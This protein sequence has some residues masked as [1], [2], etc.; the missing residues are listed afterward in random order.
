MRSYAHTEAATFESVV[1][2]I[3]H[4]KRASLRSRIAGQ[5]LVGTYELDG[6]HRGEQEAEPVREA[7]AAAEK[8]VRRTTPR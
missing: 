7:E 1:S 8:R 6:V 5:A 3:S 4:A 2:S